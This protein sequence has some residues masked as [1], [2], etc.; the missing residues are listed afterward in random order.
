M[1][2]QSRQNWQ[3][4][5][6]LKANQ[7]VA[8]AVAAQA[9]PDGYYHWLTS[10]QFE[11]RP[12]SS[13]RRSDSGQT[14]LCLDPWVNAEFQTNGK[15]TACCNLGG[16]EDLD[17]WDALE[18]LRDA[19]SFQE[20]RHGLLTGHLHP[21]CQT[22]HIRPMGP[23]QKQVQAVYNHV[24]AGQSLLHAVPLKTARVDI[25]EECNLR[26]VYCAVSQPGYA[27]VPMRDDQMDKLVRLLGPYTKLRSLSV[28]GHG[29]TTHH[30][31]WKNFCRPLIEQ[32]IPLTIITNLGKKYTAEDFDVLSRFDIIQISI[33]TADEDLLKAVRR[34]VEI[35]RIMHNMAK[36]R[37][38]ALVD[39]RKAPRM[40]FSAGLYDLSIQRLEEFAWFAVTQGI[41]MIT[42]WNLVKYPDLE[43][44]TTVRTLDSL[45]EP[46]LAEA[47]AAFDRA[48][49]IFDR[50]EIQIEVAGGFIEE[51][52][53]RL[54]DGSPAAV[55]S[56]S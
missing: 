2:D 3:E 53:T 49:V 29:E 41:S 25:N 16:M 52:R 12:G 46:D 11:Q 18:D 7:D 45:D 13:L 21:R 48:M 47:I 9:M 20:L 44:A 4:E 39:G 42:F 8:N 50:F 19:E 22:C 35:S 33:D 14:R 38:T 6:Y 24:G 56:A 23:V 37:T 55:T 34:K 1:A 10:G 5:A 40:A 26:C 54:K 27:G 36:I 51:L 15:V 30:P 32:G 17:D 28:N 31:R 43:G